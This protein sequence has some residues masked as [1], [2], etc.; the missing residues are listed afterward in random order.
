MEPPQGPPLAN[1][2]TLGVR[3]V[4]AQRA[5]YLALGWPLVLDSEDFVVFELRGALRPVPSG[6]V[7]CRRARGARNR[8][9][10]HPVQH[11]HHR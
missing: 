7:G 8:T 2:I 5:F 9:G 10:R 3:N 11:H 4:D 6:E 1:T